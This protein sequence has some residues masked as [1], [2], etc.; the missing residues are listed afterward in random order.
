MPKKTLVEPVY[1]KTTGPYY[2]F[3]TIPR[4]HFETIVDSL[5]KAGCFQEI[6]ES[7][8]GEAAS[9]RTLDASGRIQAIVEYAA[10]PSVYRVR[11]ALL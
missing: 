10:T 7:K 9:I 8:S 1:T 4:D 11:S 6:T 2:G 3:T 5:T